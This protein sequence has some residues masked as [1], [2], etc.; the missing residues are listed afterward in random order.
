MKRME[1]AKSE[2]WV[3]TEKSKSKIGRQSKTK[4]RQW[5][6]TRS[7]SNKFQVSFKGQLQQCYTFKYVC[8]FWLQRK[9]HLKWWIKTQWVCC[10]VGNVGIWVW[11]AV[12]WLKN[13]NSITLLDSLKDEED[14]GAAAVDTD[15]MSVCE[16]GPGEPGED[17]ASDFD[18]VCQTRAETGGV[19]GI[20]SWD[21]P[22]PGVCPE[23]PTTPYIVHYIVTTPF[24]SA[25]WMFSGKYYTPV[26][27]LHSFRSGGPPLLNPSRR[28]FKFFI[29]YFFKLWQIHH[30]RIRS[31][32]SQ[33]SPAL[34]R[35]SRVLR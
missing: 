19:H 13:C 12:Y 10:I 30:R 5:Q 35:V 3:K 4:S 20:K 9:L 15:E 2:N 1:G 14:Q 27:P 11:K 26:F 25:V 29:F 32:P 6:V 31:P 34:G 23:S 28:S 24:C 33:A 21:S 17:S 18:G 8:L 7:R 22:R 16:K